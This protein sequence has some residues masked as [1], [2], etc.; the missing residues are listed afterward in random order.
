MRSKIEAQPQQR[1]LPLLRLRRAIA[2]RCNRGGPSF[3][4]VDHGC[5][6][7]AA[8]TTVTISPVVYTQ[9]MRWDVRLLDEVE[10]WLLGLDDDSYDLVAAAIDKLADEVPR[11]VVPWSTL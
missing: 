3:V 10:A 11:W 2:V 7:Q 5:H 6:T 8:R 4:R 9:G 1:A